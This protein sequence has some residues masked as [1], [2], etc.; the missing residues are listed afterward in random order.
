[1][2]LALIVLRETTEPFETVGE[3]VGK[4][5]R[6]RGS[7][8]EDVGEEEEAEKR[9]AICSVLHRAGAHCEGRRER[10]LEREKK[11]RYRREGKLGE[12]EEWKKKKN[13]RVP[14]N[15]AACCKKEQHNGN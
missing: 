14:E 4:S 13:V 2:F 8:M 7:E 6:D 10:E 12:R 1:M 11:K 5:E 15:R 9:D 3:R